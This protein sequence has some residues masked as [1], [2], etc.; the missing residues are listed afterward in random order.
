MDGERTRVLGCPVDAVDMDFAVSR[1]LAAVDDDRAGRPSTTNGVVVTLN[2]EILMQARGRKQLLSVLDNAYLIIPD[3]AGL[4]TAL[5]RRGFERQQRVTGIDLISAYLPQAEKLGHRVAFVGA[6]PGIAERAAEIVRR[7]FPALHLIADS[8]D[9]NADTVN[10]LKEAHAEVV[11]AAYGGGRQEIFLSEYLTEMGAAIG[12]GVGG[13]LDYLAR[14]V[15]RAPKVVRDV[16]LEWAWRLGMQPW[17][18]KRQ[19]VLPKF[20]WLERREAAGSGR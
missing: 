10:R 18:I 4:V 3:G 19:M 14:A 2:P 20:W 17:R 9:P 6:A 8:G 5:R 15:K 12:I 16:N 13:T 1:I 11:L 7:Q